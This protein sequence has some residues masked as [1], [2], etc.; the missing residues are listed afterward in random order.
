MPEPRQKDDLGYGH[1]AI[2]SRMNY[3]IRMG[4]KGNVFWYTEDVDELE[5]YFER[6]EYRT[7]GTAGCVT[8]GATFEELQTTDPYRVLYHENKNLVLEIFDGWNDPDLSVWLNYAINERTKGHPNSK[9]GR[10]TLN[11]T[12]VFGW[13]L[14]GAQSIIEHETARGRVL[15]PAGL[16]TDWALYND[17]LRDFQPESKFIIRS[18]YSRPYNPRDPEDLK[19]IIGMFKGKVKCDF[20]S[21]KLKNWTYDDLDKYYEVEPVRFDGIRAMIGKE[22]IYP[23]HLAGKTV[24]DVKKA[25]ETPVPGAAVPGGA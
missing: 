14:Y 7:A 21:P 6:W 10:S 19:A 4:T 11:L 2:Q 20:W 15:I 13:L 3:S 25:L 16:K 24:Q 23:P 5:Y 8:S 17:S 18:L 9:I 12:G 22:I 1:S